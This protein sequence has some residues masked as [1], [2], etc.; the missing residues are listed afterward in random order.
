[1]PP[2]ATL[3]VFR[4]AGIPLGVPAESV[5]S[6]VMPPDHLTHP[7]GSRSSMPGIF[8]HAEHVHAV[9]DLHARLGI[10]PN[11]K[12]IGRLLLYQETNRHYAFLVDEVVG[13]I[14]TQEGQ[15]ATL[16]PYLPRKLF[17]SG[18]LHHDEIVLCTEL[19]S[20]RNMHDASPLHQHLEHTASLAKASPAGQAKAATGLL[21]ATA[22]A[23]ST[24]PR[25][26]TDP[27]PPQPEPKRDEKKPLAPPPQQPLRP[28][29]HHTT[30]L[31]PHQTTGVTKPPVATPPSPQPAVTR[32]AIK[33]RADTAKPVAPDIA[34]PTREV[35]EFEQ[36]TRKPSTPLLWLLPLLLLIVIAWYLWP[37]EPAPEPV[38]YSYTPPPASPPA[39]VPV[40][41]PSVQESAPMALTGAAP[42]TLPEPA[43]PDPLPLSIERNEDGE[44]HLIIERSALLAN[45]DP[46][47]AAASTAM[48]NGP[49]ESPTSLPDADSQPVPDPDKDNNEQAL[50]QPIEAIPVSVESSLDVPPAPSDETDVWFDPQQRQLEP[51]ECVHIVVRG[52]TLWSIARRYTGNAFNYPILARRSG[53]H[54]PHWIYPGDRIR[55]TIR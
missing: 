53:I 55:I 14:E 9:I 52:D 18:F 16:P 40:T 35:S 23:T 46:A 36:T 17:W 32:H 44:L 1:M 47:D 22:T 45:I 54:D 42:E 43:R 50:S 13:L 4:I 30:P 49:V 11:G 15:W 21:S 29:T 5:A 31:T 24:S 48:E 20:L 10:E 27:A 51:C 28:A 6:I 38:R 33:E 19:S 7:P 8:R 37:G 2:T 39:P 34:Y 12:R 25:Q 3:L 26:V 41:P